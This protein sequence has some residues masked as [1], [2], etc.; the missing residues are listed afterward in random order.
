MSDPMLPNA[1]E[2]GPASLLNAVF[3][4]YMVGTYSVMGKGGAQ[5]IANM[6]GEY[7]GREILAYAKSQ[8]K[9]LNSAGALAKFFEENGLAGAVTVSENPDIV[10]IQVAQCG[11]CPKRVGKYQFD[12]TACPWGGVM[13]GALGTILQK[14][15]S[16]SAGLKPAEA[17]TITL[18]FRK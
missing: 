9:T 18:K 1:R 15:F 17:C 10:A 7:V 13:I 5:A 14:E 12:G 3:I 16:V 6:A 2:K 11:I 4:G 8:G